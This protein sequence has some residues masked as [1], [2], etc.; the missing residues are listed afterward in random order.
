[1]MAVQLQQCINVAAFRLAVLFLLAALS[2]V[3]AAARAAQAVHQQQVVCTVHAYGM[4]STFREMAAQQLQLQQRINVVAF[5]Q[6]S[7][8]CVC[9]T[10][11]LQSLAC[12]VPSILLA[13]A[14]CHQQQLDDGA[15]CAAFE[16]QL[17]C[18]LHTLFSSTRN[19]SRP[20]LI[21]C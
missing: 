21:I 18:L 8:V 12:A 19:D 14:L 5:G 3:S 13:T 4:L 15:L 1:M 11:L 9:C 20:P 17:V 2:V 6:A 16:I 10:R 7:I